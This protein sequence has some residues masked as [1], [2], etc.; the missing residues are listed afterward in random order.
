[1]GLK[2]TLSIAK[3]PE[4]EDAEEELDKFKV[5]RGFK[6]DGWSCIPSLFLET[7]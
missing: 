6:F 4:I 7:I 5:L 3:A 1:M 2:R